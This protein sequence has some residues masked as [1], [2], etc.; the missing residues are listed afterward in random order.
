ML[1][2][3]IFRLLSDINSKFKKKIPYYFLRGYKRNLKTCN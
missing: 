2:N 3:G 1:S